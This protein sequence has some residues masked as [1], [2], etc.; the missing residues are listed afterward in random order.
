MSSQSI[1]TLQGGS[2]ANGGLAKPMSKPVNIVLR[3]RMAGAVIMLGGIATI[4]VYFT[5]SGY[6]EQNDYFQASLF[7]VVVDWFIGIQLLRQKSEYMVLAIWRVLIGCSVYLMSAIFNRD[8]YFAVVTV[9][10]GSYF[11]VLGVNT[12][13]LRFRIANF[14]ILPFVLLLY[15]S[16]VVAQFFPWPEY[17]E[18]SLRPLLH[19]APV[20][21]TGLWR[22]KP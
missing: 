1:A 10:I 11:L 4:S 6:I 21:L 15:L 3:N 5:Q 2:L 12:T 14:M 13:R 18:V 20:D 19:P 8:P 17:G 16:L 22:G 7:P 9:V